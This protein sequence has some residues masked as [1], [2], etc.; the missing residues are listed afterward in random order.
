MRIRLFS[1]PRLLLTAVLG[2]LSLLSGPAVAQSGD[3]IEAVFYTV[4][5]E[6]SYQSFAAHREQVSVVA[7]QT[8]SVDGEGMVWGEVSRQLIEQARAA[9]TRVV[10]LVVND[11]FN[12]EMMHALLTDSTARARAISMMVRYAEQYGFDG[13]QFDFEN[14]RATDRARYTTFC[15]EAARAFDRAGL[16][17]SIAMVPRTSD[18]PGPTSYH[19]WIYANWRGPF[20]LK[21]LADT[22][23]FLSLMTYDQHTRGTTPGPISGVPWVESIVQFA[24]DQGV[25]ADKISL[26][27]PLY[28]GHWK[29]HY[30]EDT[31]AAARRDGVTYDTVQRLLARHDAELRWNATQKVHH[32]HW[33][34]AGVFEYLFVE[35]QRSFRAK[36]EL[37]REYDLRGF[38][39]WRLGQEDPGIW[40]V[41]EQSAEVR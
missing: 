9:D 16:E 24:L 12:Q 25:P 15:Q 6:S 14:I 34:R 17:F 1:V 2:A 8:F 18:V 27:I 38:S 41:L 37:V 28:S 10:P 20:D 19:R 32:T 30:D 4:A 5:T 39:S 13:W 36:L 21:A 29:P 22:A 23:D 33:T 40:T 31:G 7:P 3:P 11:G 35:D 26:G